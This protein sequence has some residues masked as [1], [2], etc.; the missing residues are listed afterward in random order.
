MSM[1][2]IALIGVVVMLVLLFM[3]MHIGFAMMSVGFLGYWIA[4][5]NLNAAWGVLRQVPATTAS[6]YSLCVIPLFVF[7]GNLAFAGG[8]SDGLFN[9]GDKWLGKLPGGIGCATIAACA[10]FGAICGSAPATAA[11]MGV[12]AVPK[13]K[14]FGYND[15]LSTG[16]VA[17][18]GTLGILI[19]P[20]TPMIVY[21]VM[22]EASIGRLFAGGVIPGLL[23]AVLFMATIVLKVKLHPDYAPKSDRAISWRERFAALKDLVWVVILFGIVLGGMFSGFF[24]VNES[25][26]IGCV[27]AFLIYIIRRRFTVKGFI[28]VFLDSLKSA[29]MVYFVIMGADVFGKFLTITNMS[30]TLA[31]IVGSLNISRYII[32]LIIILIYAI[33]GM[34]MDALPMI[35]LTAPIFLPVV[36]SLGFDTIWFGILCIIVMELGFI[37]PPVGMCCYVISGVCKDV[38][39]KKVFSGAMMFVPAIL[40]CAVLLAIF[41]QIAL[42]LPN[43]AYGAA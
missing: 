22:A 30:A 26:A 3:G 17:A 32:I 6:N 15:S 24:S 18:G 42:W 41:P 4:T 43:L 29:V 37:T 16:A 7:M 1:L 9:A 28:K 34:F 36:T 21:G 40:I 11:T 38:P 19:P 35:T 2:T 31:S 8:M 13:M 5:G 27:V 14:E 20:S 12:V 23:L 33:M 25:A 39:L 10:G